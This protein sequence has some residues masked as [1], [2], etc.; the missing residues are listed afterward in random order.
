MRYRRHDPSGERFPGHCHDGGGFVALQAGGSASTYTLSITLA[1]PCTSLQFR[2]R[3]V[4]L[5]GG[6]THII[7]PDWERLDSAPVRVFVDRDGDG[8]PEDTLVLA[9]EITEVEGHGALIPNEYRLEQNY[10]NPFNP[11]TTIRYGLPQKSAVRLA[12]YNLLGQEVAT[13]LQEEQE[14]GDHEV[15][16]DASGLSSGVYF[17]RLVAGA[18]IQS[19]KLILLR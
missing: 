1:A 5:S 12:V 14:A 13:L 11:I 9:N 10:P 8:T 19:R 15:K 7:T 4:A 2:H 3:G 16:F 17:Y 18:F 6:S